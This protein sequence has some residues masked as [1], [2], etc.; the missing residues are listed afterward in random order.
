V[1]TGG[2]LKTGTRFPIKFDGIW[3]GSTPSLAAGRASRRVERGIR[4]DDF[5][6]PVTLRESG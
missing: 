5:I 3:L 4:A 1:R 2:R 6:H